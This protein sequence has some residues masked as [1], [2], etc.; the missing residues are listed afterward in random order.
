MKVHYDPG[1]A[2]MANIIAV[3]ARD[4]AKVYVEQGSHKDKIQSTRLRGSAFCVIEVPLKK[5]PGKGK[6]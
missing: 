6:E 2:L 5:A 3:R 4:I 1:D